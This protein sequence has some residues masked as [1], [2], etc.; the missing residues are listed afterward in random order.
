MILLD[1]RSELLE[2]GE[3]AFRLINFGPV[4]PAW[5][6]MQEG[7]PHEV[8][9]REQRVAVATAG[10][11]EFVSRG[12]EVVI[13]SDSGVGSLSPNDVYVAAGP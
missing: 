10:L 11:F 12:H 5:P 3:L 13:E 7:V 8:K 4:A 9:N 6:M 1:R 2:V